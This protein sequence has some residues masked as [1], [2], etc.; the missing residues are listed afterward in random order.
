MI[1]VPTQR[2]IVDATSR[3]TVP[4]VG[5]MSDATIGEM[6]APA[7]CARLVQAI[8]DERSSSFSASSIARMV[9]PRV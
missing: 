6:Q 1:I 4:V 7:P 9:K 2:R 8:I 3:I 5:T